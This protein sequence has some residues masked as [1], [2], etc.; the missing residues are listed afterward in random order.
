MGIFVFRPPNNKRNAS[1][2]NKQISLPQIINSYYSLSSTSSK[3]FSSEYQP[4]EIHGFRVISGPVGEN[5][6]VTGYAISEFGLFLLSKK[7]LLQLIRQRN[8]LRLGA[9]M[10]MS[11]GMLLLLRVDLRIASTA[12]AG[13]KVAV[14]AGPGSGFGNDVYVRSCRGS[15]ASVTDVGGAWENKNCQP[16]SC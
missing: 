11:G 14:L 6:Q 2:Y 15:V 12:A 3:V 10:R 7:L 9:I 5:T 8:V 16:C 13:V 4:D 1:T